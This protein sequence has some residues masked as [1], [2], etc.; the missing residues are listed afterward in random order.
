MN[1]KMYPV[2][3]L[4][5]LFSQCTGKIY[6]LRE[7]VIFPRQSDE[8]FSIMVPVDGYESAVDQSEY[9]IGKTV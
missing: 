6:P 9:L 8:N 3:N 2:N 5:F 4:F 1:S 7:N